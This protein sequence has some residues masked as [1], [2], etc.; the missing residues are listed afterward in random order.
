VLVATGGGMLAALVPLVVLLCVGVIG[1]FLSD[2]GLHGTTRDGLR[3]GGL[4][5]L[6]AH[7]S[8]VTVQ[9]A[10]VSV[11]PL[12]LTLA[13]AWTTGRVAHRVGD[14]V[15]GHGPDA[16]RISDGERDWTVPVA[17]AL[18]LVG[19]AVVAVVT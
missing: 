4:A 15:S 19:F 8:G 1:W 10:L 18:F 14:L 12:G 13:T 7:G 3:A 16:D 9:G 2:S 11:V 17:I 5:W 6:M